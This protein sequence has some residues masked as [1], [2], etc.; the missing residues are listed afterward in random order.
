MR[1]DGRFLNESAITPEYINKA[2]ALDK[3]AKERGQT[4]AQMALSWIL[5][6]G[7]ITSVLVGASKVSQIVDDVSII[8]SAPFTKEE[9]DRIDEIL[10]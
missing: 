6:D 4:L 2:R 7:D 9:L 3:L 8:K 10:A 5:K 1:T